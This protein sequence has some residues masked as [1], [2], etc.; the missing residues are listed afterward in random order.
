MIE[1][2]FYAKGTGVIEERQI[3]GGDELVQLRTMT[4]PGG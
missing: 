3:L 1:L 2:K 4:P